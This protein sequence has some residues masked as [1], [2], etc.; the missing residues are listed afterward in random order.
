VQVAGGVARARSGNGRGRPGRSL[1][2]AA[3][4][5]RALLAVFLPWAHTVRPP[6]LVRR[7]CLEGLDVHIDVCVD[8]DVLQHTPGIRGTRRVRGG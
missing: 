8:A 3:G 4:L 1:G 7:V 5:G 6:R 2:Q